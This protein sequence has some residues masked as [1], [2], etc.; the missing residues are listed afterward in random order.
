MSAEEGWAGTPGRRTLSPQHALQDAGET[1]APSPASVTMAGPATPRME[2]VF[3]PQAGPDISAWKVP[4]EAELHAPA[5]KSALALC[6][7]N[8]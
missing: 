2:A 1:A 6:P 8:L 3:A 7:G 5:P 4:T